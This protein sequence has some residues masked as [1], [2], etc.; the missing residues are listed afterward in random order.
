MNRLNLWARTGLLVALIAVGLAGGPPAAVGAQRADFEPDAYVSGLSDLEIEISGR[1][2]EIYDAELQEYPHGEGEIVSIS[3][4]TA[5]LQVAFFDDSDTNEQTLELFNESFAS[6]VD[7]FEVIDEGGRRDTV[8]TFAATSYS[9]IT[10]YYYTS[11][12]ED[13]V[14]NV[15]VLQ[16]IYSADT[17]FFDDLA[18]A[19]EDISIGGDG[20]LSTVEVDDLADM[21]GVTAGFSTQEDA[22]PDQDEANTSAEEPSAEEDEAGTGED[23][24]QRRRASEADHVFEMV[25]SELVAEGDAQVVNATYE[26]PVVEQVELQLEGSESMALIQLMRNPMSSESTLDFMLGSF[27]SGLDSLENI[28]TDAT[29]TSAWSL[30]Y[31]E[32]GGDSSLVFIWVDSARYDRVHYVEVLIATEDTF[33]ED[34]DRLASQVSVDGEPMLSGVDR[35]MI[36][37][38]LQEWSQTAGEGE[39]E[40]S[41]GSLDRRSGRTSTKSTTV[42]PD[43]ELQGLVSETEYE[44]PQYGV[45]VEWDG[46]AWMID[47]EWDLTATSATDTGVDSVVVFRQGGNAFAM[48]QVTASQ[49]DDPGDIVA[50]WETDDFISNGVGEGAELLL[51]DTGRWSGAAVFLS[52][53]DEGGDLIVIPEVQEIDNG[54]TLAYVTMFGSPD[55]IADAYADA[56]DFIDVDGEDAVG[57][58]T[59]REL[60]SSLAQ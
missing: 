4:L 32:A 45:V 22:G 19:Q 9:D 24:P 52:S 25:P 13:V 44:S 15:D 41:S 1:D 20:F 16:S 26:A 54:G 42:S 31:G 29:A 36:E 11:V 48:I 8:Y 28:G 6:V 14:G 12:T 47:P 10:F 49:G 37:G 46:D 33:L 2:Y 38:M 3:S 18:V 43:L 17:T 50:Y 30:D 34:L 40:A 53:D 39:D 21:A 55:E 58:F 23:E 51:S 56:E 7:D 57:V 5:F 59:A 27:Q 35:A 60:E